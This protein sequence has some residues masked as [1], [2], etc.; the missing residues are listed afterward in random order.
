MNKEKLKDIIMYTTLTLVGI[1]YTAFFL[2]F[3]IYRFK[4]FMQAVLIGSSLFIIFWSA[5]RLGCKNEESLA[6]KRNEV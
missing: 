5:W 1:L 2:V 4:E 3:V 6:K